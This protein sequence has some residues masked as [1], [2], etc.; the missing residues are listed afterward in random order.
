M[1]IATEYAALTIVFYFMLC[2]FF[3][4]VIEFDG[5]YAYQ[6]FQNGLTFVKALLLCCTKVSVKLLSELRCKAII[7]VQC[8]V[9]NLLSP[10]AFSKSILSHENC[11][12]HSVSI[13]S[14]TYTYPFS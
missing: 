11:M 7:F 12:S 6:A 1:F 2:S 3:K 14:G 4:T 9:N 10:V 13:F 8:N 5:S